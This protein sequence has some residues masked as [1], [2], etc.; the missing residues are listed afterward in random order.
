MAR[1]IR[2]TPV[3][4]GKNARQFEKAMREVKP[5]CK[6]KRDAMR[7]EYEDFRSKLIFKV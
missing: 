4:R 7:K 2:E 6:E 1:A 3:L 5:Y